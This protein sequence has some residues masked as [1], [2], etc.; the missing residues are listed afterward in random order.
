VDCLSVFDER[1][2]ETLYIDVVVMVSPFYDLKGYLIVV[3][4]IDRILNAMLYPIF[5]VVIT[6]VVPN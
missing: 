6:L 3:S 5:L 1:V 2:T 4:L